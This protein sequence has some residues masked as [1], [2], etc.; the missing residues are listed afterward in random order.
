[1][2]LLSGQLRQISL[3]VADVDEAVAFYGDVL[4]LPLMARFASLAF[5]DLGGVRLLV[6]G[7]EGAP[8]RNSV[9][10]FVVDDPHATRTALETRGVHFVDE[11]HLI[12]DDT[13]GTF[14]DPGHGEW[15]T[16]FEDP[17]G[18]LLALSA[19]LPSG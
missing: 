19:R 6:S 8:V 2:T 7:A 16:F 13:N 10:Y 17:E 15:M 1:M 9:L 14:G 12:F 3:S 11:P 4:E 18:N 5:F